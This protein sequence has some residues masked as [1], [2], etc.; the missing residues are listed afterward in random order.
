MVM[1][2]V[3]TSHAY[4][5]PISISHL[6]TPTFG[7]VICALQTQ[8]PT[9]ACQKWD[10]RDHHKAEVNETNDNITFLI[11]QKRVSWTSPST[12]SHL[13]I[14]CLVS[15]WLVIVRMCDKMKISSSSSSFVIFMIWLNGGRVVEPR[16]RWDAFLLQM[17]WFQSDWYFSGCVTNYVQGIKIS[18]LSSSS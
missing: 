9:T 11:L 15:E 2:P 14:N 13:S 10:Q 18:S 12:R 17:V 6:I 16:L 4:N 5:H 8:K 1:H 7:S 3:W